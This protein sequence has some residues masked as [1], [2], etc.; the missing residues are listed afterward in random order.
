MKTS[1]N[2][3]FYSY[4]DSQKVPRPVAEFQF[5]PDRLWRF[6]YA[7]PS[8]KLALEVDGGVW[9]SGRH[10][11]GS[12]YIGDMEKFNHAAMSGWRVLRVQPNE[13][14]KLQTIKMIRLCLWPTLEEGGV[15]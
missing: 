15:R 5:H 12:G 3:F 11:R 9:T 14:L 8:A 4:L 7:W 6:D 1:N 10:T 2:A 13:L